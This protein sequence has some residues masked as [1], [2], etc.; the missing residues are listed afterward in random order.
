MKKSWQLIILDRD[1]V[2][3]EDSDDYVKSADEWRAIP[4]SLEAIAAINKLTIPVVVCTN[5]SGLARGLFS[6]QD[7]DA[8]HEKLTRELK[9]VGG[10]IDKIYACTHHPDDNCECRKPKPGM[11]LQAAKDFNA[12]PNHILVI[13]DSARDIEAAEAAGFHSILVKTGK[14]ERTL[15]KNTLATHIPIYENLAEAVKD[16]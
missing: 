12:D 13:G 10:H 11:Y 2:I 4:A 14:G 16:L 1:G 5:Q 9:A 3:N 7:L 6:Q 15:A 8:M